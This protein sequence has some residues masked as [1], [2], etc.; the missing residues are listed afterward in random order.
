MGHIKH[1]KGFTLIELIL[2]MAILALVMAVALP[3]VSRFSKGRSLVEESRRFLTLT[4]YGRSEAISLATPMELWLEPESG[5]FGLEPLAGYTVEAA[6]RIEWNLSDGIA[7]VIDAVD[8]NDQGQASIIFQPDGVIDGDSPSELQLQGDDDELITI[9]KSDD[10]T[11]YI[12]EQE[13]QA[14]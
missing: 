10:L 11:G 6:K 8:L 1:E 14:P 9:V 13:A 5:A 12:I 3:S 7:F 2:V 4:A